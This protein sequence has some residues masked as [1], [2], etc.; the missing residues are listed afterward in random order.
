[1]GAPEPELM[2][3]GLDHPRGLLPQ[4]ARRKIYG[5]RQ[6]EHPQVLFFSLQR[7]L[8]QL[9]LPRAAQSAGWLVN[10]QQNLTCLM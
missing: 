10:R 8:S 7:I 5:A 2:T 4:E 1:M 9:R 3:I 6:P